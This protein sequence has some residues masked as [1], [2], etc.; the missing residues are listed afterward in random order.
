MDF[1]HLLFFINCF[2]YQLILNFDNHSSRHSN[3]L[4]SKLFHL[5]IKI[6]LYSD[7]EIYLKSTK[8]AYRY[9]MHIPEAN[10][11]NVQGSCGKRCPILNWIKDDDIHF[12]EEIEWWDFYLFLYFSRHH[13]HK[14]ASQYVFLAC[15]DNHGSL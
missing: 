14:Y 12:Q 6:S 11:I 13:E 1:F 4:N 8:L 2:R 15:F 7:S 3:K 10:Q 5:R 9:W